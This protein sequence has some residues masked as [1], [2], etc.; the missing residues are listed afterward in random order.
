[1][2]LYGDAWIF[3]TWNSK[4]QAKHFNKVLSKSSRKSLPF[5]MRLEKKV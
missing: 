5:L 4:T 1:M 2:L 3:Y